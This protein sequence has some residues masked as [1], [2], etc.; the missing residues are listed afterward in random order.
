MAELTLEKLERHLFVAT[1]ILRGLI[2]VLAM[3]IGQADG[4]QI[5][6]NAVV[7]DSVSKEKSLS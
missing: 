3:L 6:D 2:S 7:P 1:D 4:A 5:R